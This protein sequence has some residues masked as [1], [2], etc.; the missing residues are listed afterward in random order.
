[1]TPMMMI[2]MTTMR[3]ILLPSLLKKIREIQSKIPQ[4]LR[5]HV[6]SCHRVNTFVQK[7]PSPKL[8]SFMC[9]S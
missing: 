6:E 4:N 1:M 5:F 7:V 3:S 8:P 9:V 2:V